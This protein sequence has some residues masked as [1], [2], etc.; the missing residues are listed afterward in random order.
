MFSS[1]LSLLLIG[2]LLPVACTHHV[3]TTD[4]SAQ[5]ASTVATDGGSTDAAPPEVVNEEED[6]GDGDDEVAEEGES[7]EVADGGT[8]LKYTMDVSDVDLQEKW[9]RA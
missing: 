4:A 5:V 2:L 9:K 7:H 6:T 1:R 3:R 8:A